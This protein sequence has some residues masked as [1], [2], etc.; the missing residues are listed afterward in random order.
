M[1]TILVTGA[2]GFIGSHIARRLVH[3]GHEVFVLTREESSLEAIADVVSELRVVQ[4]DLRDV[5]ELEP[6][7]ARM[8]PEICVHAAW[9][10]VPGSYL[11]AEE[12]VRLVG[13]TAELAS[14]LA[15]VGCRRF[16]GIG[17]CFEYD[18]TAGIL[19]ERTPTHPTNLYAASKLATFL[20][21]KQL[22]ARAGMEVAWARLFYQ[23]GPFEDD[24]RL[25]PAVIQ[26]LLR[27]EEVRLTSGNQ[28]R[29]FLHV[30]DVAAA[31][32]AVSHSTV[33]GAVNVGSAEAITVR[34]LVEMIASTL[35]RPDLLVFGALPERLGDPPVVCADNRRLVEEC[36]WHQATPHAEGLLETIEWWRS[37]LATAVRP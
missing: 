10:A 35:S 24:R 19:S 7:L 6:Q 36:G 22:G 9:Y 13:A 27:A 4:G 33:T 15:R 8:A 21:T 28:V 32:S 1:R 25:V 30:R 29:D 18:T 20:L 3:E 5:R 11:D 17:S 2:T 23:Y 37:R 14:L 16:V 31:V 12:N 34:A 26:A